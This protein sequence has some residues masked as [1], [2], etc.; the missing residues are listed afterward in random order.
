M[1]IYHKDLSQQTISACQ[2][3][4]KKLSQPDI[5]MESLEFLI[6]NTVYCVQEYLAV[7]NAVQKHAT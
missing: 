3:R 7:T 1:F 4:F 5:L 6:I 2:Q